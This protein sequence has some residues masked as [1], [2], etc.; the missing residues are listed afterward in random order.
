MDIRATQ[1][2]EVVTG[3]RIKGGMLRAHLEWVR[4]THGEAALTQLVS[5][6][7]AEVSHDVQSVLPTTWCAFATLVTLDRAIARQYGHNVLKDL[8]RFSARINLDTTYRLYKRADIHEFFAKAAALHSQFQDFG[9]ATYEQ[10]GDHGGRMIHA[11]YPCFSP[12]FCAS[13]IGYYEEAL[14]IHNGRNVIVTESGCQCAG[15]ASCTFVMR[16]S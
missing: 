7:A 16:W 15:D 2:R 4:R 13:A 10:N 1:L 8:G 11:G 6:L 14:R 5:S 12:V 3:G 9:S